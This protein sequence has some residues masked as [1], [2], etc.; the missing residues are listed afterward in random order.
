MIHLEPSVIALWFFVRSLLMTSPNALTHSFPWT[1]FITIL[2]YSESLLHC[3]LK[4]WTLYLQ[5]EAAGLNNNILKF[6]LYWARKMMRISEAH[7]WVNLFKI[8]G[9]FS[10]LAFVV[11]IIYKCFRKKCT[12]LQDGDLAVL[13]C[14]LPFCRL[15]Y[16]INGLV[17]LMRLYLIAS[18]AIN[19]RPRFIC[20][21]RWMSFS[22][23]RP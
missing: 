12:R 2:S 3:W 16:H 22:G 8:F 6:L 13:L 5:R 1:E 7:S 14:L 21:L 19:V 15:C 11:I 20:W 10:S 17:C 9:K 4:T 18:L 23:Q